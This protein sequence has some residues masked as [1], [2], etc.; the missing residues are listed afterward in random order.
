MCGRV[1]QSGGPLIRR[2]SRSAAAKSGLLGLTGRVWRELG[3]SRDP[4]Q[5]SAA[6]A[7][8]QQVVKSFRYHLTDPRQFDIMQSGPGW[9]ESFKDRRGVPPPNS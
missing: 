6:L 1:V 4:L 7:N 5:T 9:A 3:K 8:G 2:K